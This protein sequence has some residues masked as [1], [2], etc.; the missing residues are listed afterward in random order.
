M[1]KKLP[2][3]RSESNHVLKLIRMKKQQDNFNRSK[4]NMTELFNQTYQTN[5][6]SGMVT[7][8]GASS[9]IYPGKAPFKEREK[10]LKL[11]L[12]QQTTTTFG[13]SLC[14]PGNFNLNAT[15]QLP[16]RAEAKKPIQ[17]TVYSPKQQHASP[18]ANMILTNDGSATFIGFGLKIGES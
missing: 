16:G 18:K 2:L 10:F 1:R 7:R 8:L 17:R 12:L 15:F 5:F 4:A 9:T 11:P 13:S 14:Q 6:G 3:E